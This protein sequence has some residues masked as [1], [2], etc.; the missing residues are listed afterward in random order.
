MLRFAIPLLTFHL[1][2][3]NQKCVHFTRLQIDRIRDP[4]P[5]PHEELFHQRKAFASHKRLRA[6]LRLRLLPSPDDPRFAALFNGQ[7]TAPPFLLQTVLSA[8]VAIPPGPVRK[9]E[10]ERDC[11]FFLSFSSSP[12]AALTAARASKNNSSG[13]ASTN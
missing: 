10:V 9:L 4:E 3:Q 8:A 5:A 13:P 7:K 12:H 6:F 2:P 11:Q 1:I